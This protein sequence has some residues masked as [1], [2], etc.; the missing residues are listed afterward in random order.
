MSGNIAAVFFPRNFEVE[1][2]MWV[3]LAAFALAFFA[4]CVWGQDTTPIERSPQ[5]S[6]SSSAASRPQV[7]SI[8]AASAAQTPAIPPQVVPTPSNTSVEIIAQRI[9]VLA[10]VVESAASAAKPP[11]IDPWQDTKSIILNV[12]SNRLDSW[13]FGDSK[14]GFGLVARIA[15]ILA[16]V[17]ALIRLLLAIAMLNPAA[18]PTKWGAFKAWTRK[19]GVVRGMNVVIGALA[20]VF[21]GAA[22]YV[23]MSAQ[24]APDISKASLT[25]LQ[26]SLV[27]CQA[28]LSTMPRL[29]QLPVAPQAASSTLPMLE[30]MERYGKTCESAI[31]AADARLLQIEGSVMAIDNK[32]SWTFTKVIAFFAWLYLLVAMT[33]LLRSA[34]SRPN[35]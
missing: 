17:I 24:G 6:G 14:G 12:I 9:D 16:F 25:A 7:A 2:T 31:R 35:T 19:S 15:A 18:P 28:N 3:G 29:Q 32:Q 30:A 5:A 26:E 10:K 20:V 34:A 21:T 8:G 11:A 22:L 23:V 27:A 13:L 4:Q 1:R 33:Y